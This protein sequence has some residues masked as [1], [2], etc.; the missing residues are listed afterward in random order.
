[1]AY[2]NL[3]CTTVQAVIYSVR[4]TFPTVPNTAGLSLKMTLFFFQG[5]E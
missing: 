2:N 5:I 4:N 3:P 1:M